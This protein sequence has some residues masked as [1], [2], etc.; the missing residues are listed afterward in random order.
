MIIICLDVKNEGGGDET[1]MEPEPLSE[2]RLPTPDNIHHFIL[3]HIS[4]NFNSQHL[5]GSVGSTV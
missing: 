1:A 2:E 5:E 3:L 4:Y